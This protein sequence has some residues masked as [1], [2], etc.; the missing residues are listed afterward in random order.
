MY[1][2]LFLDTFLL[3]MRVC[4]YIYIYIHS[5]MQRHPGECVCA[6]TGLRAQANAHMRQPHSF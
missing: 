3:C 5:L 1:V 6:E 2:C 4:E